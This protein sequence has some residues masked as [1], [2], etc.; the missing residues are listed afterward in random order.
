[1]IGILTVSNLG[2][3]YAWSTASGEG[4]PQAQQMGVEY[5]IYVN[6]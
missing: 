6:F 5:D 2:Y 4:Q 1:M 3:L